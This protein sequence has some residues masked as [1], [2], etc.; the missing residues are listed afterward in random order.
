[1]S[2]FMPI[3][4]CD[5][6]EEEPMDQFQISFETS[7]SGHVIPVVNGVNLHSSYDPIKEAQKFAASEIETLERNSRIMILGLGRGYHLSAIAKAMGDLHKKPEIVVIEPLKDIHKSYITEQ[8]YDTT[9][10]KIFSGSVSEI[11]FNPEFTDFLSRKPCIIRHKPSF[12]LHIKYFTEFLKFRAP[13]DLKSTINI[14]EDSLVKNKLNQYP[15]TLSL[16]EVCSNSK[17]KKTELD[18]Q[19]HLLLAF[20]EIAYETILG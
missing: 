8:I 14:I 7:K 16:K 15:E 4:P 13:K 10:I 5:L 2:N 1:M 6:M 12:D 3:D 9:T 17:Y 18:Q 19:D 11:F 20:N